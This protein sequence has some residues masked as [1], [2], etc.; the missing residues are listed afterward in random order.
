MKN[1]PKKSLKIQN[2][3]KIVMLNYYI[4]CVKNMKNIPKKSLKIQNNQKIV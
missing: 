1:I 3:Q 4:N 2:N